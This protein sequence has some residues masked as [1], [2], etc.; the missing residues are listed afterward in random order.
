VNAPKW[1][2]LG[3]TL[4]EA[5]QAIEKI[6]HVGG[7]KADAALA[8]IKAVLQTLDQGFKGQATP[9]EVLARIDALHASLTA[10][11]AAADA[12]LHKRFDVP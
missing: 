7:D 12:E 1:L 3:E 2:E 11:D 5:L 8:A 10:N 4:V 9:H 6:T